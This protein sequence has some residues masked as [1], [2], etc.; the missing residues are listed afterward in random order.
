ML[1]KVR[2]LIT[3]ASGAL[4]LIQVVDALSSHEAAEFVGKTA[5]VIKTIAS[6][7]TES[8]WRSAVQSVA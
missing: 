2:P 5:D 1:N 4:P 6:G 7:I 3:N 8:A